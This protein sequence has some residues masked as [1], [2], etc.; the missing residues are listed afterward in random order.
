MREIPKKNYI[1]VLLIAIGVVLLCFGLR[2]MYKSS[3]EKT[4]PSVIKDIV[5]EI[6]IDDLDNYLQE[7]PDVVLYIYD[8]SKKN[9]RDTE[10]SFKKLIV[11]NDISQYVVYVEKTD[12]IK[13]EYDLDKNSPILVAYQ[14]GVLKEV[15]SKKN[16]TGNELESFLVRNKVIEKND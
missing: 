3:G 9:N 2:S 1:I 6:K 12:K 16:I 5:H 8:S 11:D 10:K 4:Y 7:N 13:D 15:L 14:N